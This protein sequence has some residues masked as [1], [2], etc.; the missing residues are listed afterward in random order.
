MKTKRD[1]SVTLDQYWDLAAPQLTRAYFIEL[2]NLDSV[3]LAALLHMW[4]HRMPRLQ[5][6][7]L[8]KVKGSAPEQVTAVLPVPNIEAGRNWAWEADWT[9][10]IDD[11]SLDVIVA[12]VVRY[13]RNTRSTLVVRRG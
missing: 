11:P 12:R 8:Q 2:I 5:E 4:L 7:R 1:W 6:V 10:H 9:V 3:P 13:R